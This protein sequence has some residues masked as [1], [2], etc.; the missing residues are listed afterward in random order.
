MNDTRMNWVLYLSPIPEQTAIVLPKNIDVPVIQ[1]LRNQT[2]V[3]IVQQQSCAN[4]FT[5]LSA[6]QLRELDRQVI[7]Y[8]IQSKESFRSIK[9]KICSNSKYSIYEYSIFPGWNNP[10]WCIPRT[11]L[12]GPGKK[13]R[14]IQP[15]RL[16]AKLG[17]IVFRA[18]KITNCAHY[19]FS[20]RLIIAQKQPS[21][22]NFWNCIEPGVKTGVLYTGSYGPLQ[23]YTVELLNQEGVLFAYAKFGD[24]DHSQK[25]IQNEVT[26]LNN[27]R[28]L[29]LTKMRVPEIVEISLPNTLADKTLIVRNLVGGKPLHRITS[30]VVSALS[31]LFIFTAEQKI[32][33]PRYTNLLISSLMELDCSSIEKSLMKKRDE[34]VSALKNIMACFDNSILLPLGLSHGDFTRWNISA[35]SNSLYA[36]DWEE[37]KMRPPAHDIFTFLL[38]EFFLVSSSKQEKEAKQTIVELLNHTALTRYLQQIGR[39]INLSL[40]DKKL[41]CLFFFAETL[42]SNLWHLIMHYHYDFPPKNSLNIIIDIAWECCLLLANSHDSQ[43]I[44]VKCQDIVNDF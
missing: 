2:M 31:E 16:L 28:E 21:L 39:S 4:R 14:M 22:I 17:V 1:T 29:H 5:P 15:L 12:L 8:F 19:I 26:T 37:A 43:T 23:K 40:L 32:S 33:V 27:L 13:S 30:V 9:R 25:A 42:H 36:I 18:L 34:V 20:S 44:I 24:S 6:Q 35:D 41:F 11:C 3:K 38:T 7:C 10:R